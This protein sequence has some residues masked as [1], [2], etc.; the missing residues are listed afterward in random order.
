M[1][2]YFT[3]SSDEGA[4]PGMRAE[5]AGAAQISI[6][7]NHADAADAELTGEI[8]TGGQTRPRW[9][10]PPVDMRPNLSNELSINR[11][12]ALAIELEVAG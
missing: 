10:K 11:L 9:Q 5:K 6:G 8:S 4:A 12:F 7:V 1:L 2:G 3:F